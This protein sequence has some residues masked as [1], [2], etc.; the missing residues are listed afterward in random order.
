MRKRSL[1]AVAAIGLLGGVA[2]VDA[3]GGGFHGGGA[4]HGDAARFMGRPAST[5][6]PASAGLT[7]PPGA[8]LYAV[9]AA[10]RRGDDEAGHDFRQ[11]GDFGRDRDFR[12]DR[13]RIGVPGDRIGFPGG[14]INFAPRPPSRAIPVLYNYYYGVGDSYYS[15]VPSDYGAPA[16]ACPGWRSDA[17]SQTRDWPD[18]C[19]G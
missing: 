19:Q 11:D 13:D 4:S 15:N 14:A 12:R 17:S 5:H 3:R 7:P 1:A 6:R 9:A 10:E 16:N 8:P 18:N 2:Q